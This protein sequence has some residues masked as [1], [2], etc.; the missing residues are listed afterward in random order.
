MSRLRLSVL[1]RRRSSLGNELTGHRG[2]R[3]LREGSLAPR[4][5]PPACHLQQIR[6]RGLRRSIAVAVLG[7]TR[8][9]GQR[10][11]LVLRFSGRGPAVTTHGK[12]PLAP[13]TRGC[14]ELPL[15]SI[16]KFHA[17]VTCRDTLGLDNGDSRLDFPVACPSCPGCCE[18]GDSCKLYFTE[19]SLLL[20]NFSRAVPFQYKAIIVYK[21]DRVMRCVL[22]S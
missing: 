18:D 2:G 8:P 19:G 16:E 10:V 11:N 22:L 12:F 20:G 7:E 4:R 15:P 1:R 6:W 5:H 21:V 13:V 3:I 9:P 14:I 17:S